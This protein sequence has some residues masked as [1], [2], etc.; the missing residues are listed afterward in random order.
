MKPIKPNVDFN[1]S[2]TIGW[3]SG[4]GWTDVANKNCSDYRVVISEKTGK[5]SRGSGGYVHHFVGCGAWIQTDPAKPAEN[6]SLKFVD[7]YG[8]E[9]IVPKWRELFLR[10]R[11]GPMP[12]LLRLRFKAEKS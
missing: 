9:G 4:T 8:V 6:S 11:N 7:V 2:G 3:K 5:N 10:R 1:V 12:R